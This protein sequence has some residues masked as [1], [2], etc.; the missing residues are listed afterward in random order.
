MNNTCK[1][2]KGRI[3]ITCGSL[4]GRKGNICK[5]QDNNS[6]VGDYWICLD[7]G[8]K[9][10]FKKCE[11]DYCQPELCVKVTICEKQNNYCSQCGT[12]IKTNDNYCRSCGKKIIN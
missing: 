6:I 11:F 9:S 3:V 10:W 8:F 2:S 12:E 5:I 4:A 1:D 7:N